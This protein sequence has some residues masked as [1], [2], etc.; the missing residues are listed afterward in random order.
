MQEKKVLKLITNIELAVSY[1]EDQL[2]KAEA[3][4]K[5]VTQELDNVSRAL[6]SL[7]TQKDTPVCNCKE[8]KSEDVTST[9]GEKTKKEDLRYQNL[10]KNVDYCW[11][12]LESE[13]QY[14]PSRHFLIMR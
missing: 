11:K 14:T 13:G 12:L 7:S 1:A 10:A 3:S 6:K 9:S 5:Y 4:I 8:K 2:S